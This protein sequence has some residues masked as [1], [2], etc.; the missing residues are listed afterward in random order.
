M[1]ANK[2][3]KINKKFN[4]IYTQTLLMN[5]LIINNNLYKDLKENINIFNN[6]NNNNIK[7]IILKF[8]KIQIIIIKY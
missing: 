1:K 7:K 3:S 8:K 4:I 6:P 2:F 5:I